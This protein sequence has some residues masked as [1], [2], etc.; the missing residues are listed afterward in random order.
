M[1][2]DEL[3]AASADTVADY[4]AVAAAYAAGNADH[5]VSQN[6][7]ALL[8]N[9]ADRGPSLDLLDLCCAGGR[10]LIT[11]TQAGHRAVGLDGCAEFCE[12]ARRA[13]PASEVWHQDLQRLDLPGEHFDG[14]F[15]S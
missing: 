12:L 15:V 1:T 4:G 10:D 13:A 14:I 6:M 7:D 5:D 9:L 3:L 2:A 11:F 8:S